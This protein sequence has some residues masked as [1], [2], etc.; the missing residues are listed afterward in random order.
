M[1]I[2]KVEIGNLQ[3]AAAKITRPDAS[4]DGAAGE[5]ANADK[6]KKELAAKTDKAQKE[7]AAK[8]GTNAALDAALKA[9]TIAGR[10]ADGDRVPPPDE[11]FLLNYNAK[12]YMSVKSIAKK[13][14]DPAEHDSV[15]AEEKSESDESVEAADIAAETP[16]ANETT[17]EAA[18]PEIPP[19]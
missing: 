15:L 18:T 17:V 5:K 12:L 16:V 8:D 2:T 14:D 6:I 9:M 1:E 19:A 13:K 4:A 11:E 10:I 7:S 3:F